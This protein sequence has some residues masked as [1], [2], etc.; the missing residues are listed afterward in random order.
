MPSLFEAV[1]VLHLVILTM[2]QVQ[3]TTQ[4]TNKGTG[5]TLNKPSGVIT[6]NNAALGAAGEVSF[7]VTNDKLV[8]QPITSLLIMVLAV[9]RVH[10]LLKQIQSLRVLLKS[11][12]QTFLAVH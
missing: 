5:V 12:L 11:Q 4:A 10:T 2:T 6:M 1:R 9:Q 3:L 7:A 8:L